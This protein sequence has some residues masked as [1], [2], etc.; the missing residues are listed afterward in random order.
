MSRVAVDFSAMPHLSFALLF[1]FCATLLSGA[2]ETQSLLSPESSAD[3]PQRSADIVVYG[4]SPAAY[5][6]A[7]HLR[8]AGK[9][10]LLVSPVTH[11]GGMMIEG[12]GSQDVDARSGNGQPIGGLAREFYLRIARAYDPAATAPRY[13]FESKVAQRVIEHWL[14]ETGVPLLA[15]QPL[16]ETPEAVQRDDTRITEIRLLDGTPIRGRIFIDATVEGDLMAR[17]GVAYTWGREGNARYGEATNGIVNPTTTQQYQVAVDPYVTPGDP[18]SG[19][20]RGVSSEPLGVNGAPDRGSMAFC[21]RLP[22]TKNPAN[23]IE[24]TAPPGYT[25]ADYELYRR[26]L[27]AGGTN[28]W[29]DGPGE[30]RSPPTAKLID[31][32]SWHELSGNLVGRNHDYPD[33]TYATRRRIYDEHRDYT[34]GLIYFL[35]HDPAVPETVRAEWSQ[36]GLCKD[37]FTDNG[38][39]PRRLYVRAARRMI[40]DYVV[41]EANVRKAAIGPV[42]PAPEVPDSI[43]LCWWPT[44]YHNARTV[45]HEGRVYNEGA[46]HDKTNYRPFGIAY[47]ALVPKRSECTNLIVPAALSSSYVAYSAIRLEWTFM[48]LGES[49]GA[50]AGVALEQNLGVQDVPYAQLRKIL[51]A[52]G[53]VLDVPPLRRTVPPTGRTGTLGNPATAGSS[54]A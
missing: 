48:V 14:A 34:Q 31:L 29:L 39:W 13:R 17:S 3:A 54:R 46:L 49:A 36:W 19:L 21:F 11:V 30:P 45:V 51:Q 4:D 6:A 26:F 50:A 35:S 44:D 18:S 32:G 9:D 22:L 12:L 2:Q 53:Q 16:E 38:G 24:I 10:V 15:G 52:S 27:A 28:N 47:R 33:G 8:R 7:I 5:T 20:L 37:E 25:P 23:K 41:T 42:N 40:S 43:G 1:L